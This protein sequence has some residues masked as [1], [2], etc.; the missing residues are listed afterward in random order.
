M[1]V[2]EKDREINSFIS[3]IQVL[4]KENSKFK[5]KDYQKEDVRTLEDLMLRLNKS[6]KENDELKSEVSALKRIQNQQSRALS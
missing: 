6:L 5:N 2:R 4:K 3:T 1:I